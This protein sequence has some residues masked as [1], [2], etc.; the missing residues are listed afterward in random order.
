METVPLV[1]QNTDL[2]ALRLALLLLADHA[3]IAAA[4]VNQAQLD[5]QEHQEM[6]EIQE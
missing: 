6:P 3:V 4:E 1:K 5:H 2:L